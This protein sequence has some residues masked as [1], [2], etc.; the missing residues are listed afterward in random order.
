MDMTQ[1]N[2]KRI[3]VFYSYARK[4]K[5]LRDRLAAHLTLLKRQGFIADWSDQDVK[6]GQE[7][8]KEVSKKLESAD[9]I[10]LL[11]SPSFIETN[12]CES[13]EVDIALQRHEAGEA[14]VIPILLRSVDWESSAIGKLQALPYNLKP[15][16][17]WSNRDSA[18][19]E[20]SKNIRSLVMDLR[21]TEDKSKRKNTEEDALLPSDRVMTQPRRRKKRDLYKTINKAGEYTIGQR[22][23][24]TRRSIWWRN[25][26]FDAANRRIRGISF[27]LLFLF[28]IS[29]VIVLPLVVFQWIGNSLIV[30][31]IFILSLLLFLMGITCK[32]N[33]IAAAITFVYCVVWAILGY[34]YL[35]GIYQLHL[36][37]FSALLISV[38]FSCLQ[39]LLFYTRSPKRRRLPFFPK[40]SVN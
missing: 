19:T 17:L 34:F 30:A 4:E 22:I 12:Y 13:T 18:F 23:L 11:V 27:L 7:W 32:N 10:L 1:A 26:S 33:I 16:D 28:S 15:V 2:S 9:I 3:T 40:S 25:F 21:S 35:N 20:I 38:L 36:T 24:H 14:W 5:Q 31:I 8:R 29:E 39:L 37:F 6:P